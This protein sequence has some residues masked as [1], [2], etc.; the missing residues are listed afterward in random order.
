MKIKIFFCIIF[1][2]FLFAQGKKPSWVEQRPAVRGYYIGIAVAPKTGTPQEYIQR[3]KDGALNDIAQQIVVTINANQTSKLSEKLGDVQQEYQ[4]QV[5]TST[6]AELDGVETVAA[7]ESDTDYWLYLRLS[8]EKYEQLRAEKI[9]KATAL[10]LDF[11]SKAKAIEKNDIPH[12]IQFYVQSLSAVQKYLAEQLQVSYS[13]AQIMLGNELFSSL[14]SLLN[15]IEL[16]PKNPKL[17]GQVGSAVR[18]PVEVTA[19]NI[20]DNTPMKNLAIGFSFLRGA[21]ELV[22][23]VPTNASGIASTQVTKITATD[24]LQIIKAEVDLSSL[25]GA[26][27]RSALFET[28]LKSFTIPSARILLNITN[29]AIYFEVEESILGNPMKLPRIEPALK[30]ELSSKGFSFV[31]DVSKATLMI[32]I[33]ANGRDGGEYQGM[34]TVYADANISVTDLTSGEE[35]YKTAVTNFK[36]ISINY[37]KAGV[38]AYDELIGKLISEVLPAI[39]QRMRK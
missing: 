33:K 8:I 38:K 11:Y 26:S 29:Q 3:A 18:Q 21:G 34:Y 6:A 22:A 27:E 36:G 35:I 24:K 32:T 17:E 2:F 20:A 23:S 4:S 15:Q 25:L 37:D 16:K 30:Q 9:R 13:G 1:P 14:Q 28:L 12:A 5:K 31:D 10:A 19:T 7:W 39:L